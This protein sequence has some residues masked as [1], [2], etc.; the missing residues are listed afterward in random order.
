VAASKPIL[1]ALHLLRKR[2]R[3]RI[4]LSTARAFTS[5]DLRPLRSR[6]R[7]VASL[8]RRRDELLVTAPTAEPAAASVPV[9]IASA[10]AWRVRRADVGRH[11]ETAPGVAWGCFDPGGAGPPTPLPPVAADVVLVTSVHVFHD[12]SF[13]C[14]SSV[15]RGRIRTCGARWRG[16]FFGDLTNP[17][18]RLTSRVRVD[19]PGS[20]RC[21]RG[22]HR[23]RPLP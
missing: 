5:G 3:A 13:V 16:S 21:S 1:H 12:E 2:A 9:V 15:P 4:A 19:P 14:G 23:R 8:R 17:T 7:W 6:A 20:S 22:S 18:G 10:G 11:D